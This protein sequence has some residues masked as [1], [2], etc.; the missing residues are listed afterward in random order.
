MSSLA[1]ARLG[2]LSRVASASGAANGSGVALS[3]NG[4]QASSQ[5]AGISGASYHSSS[6]RDAGAGHRWPT[7]RASGSTTEAATAS[8]VRR[9]IPW[10]VILTS[11][12]GL[13][14]IYHGACIFL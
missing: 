1:L 10:S 8:E 4:N 12:T 5:L 2:S 14:M 6:L 7:N 13:I 9:R 3:N 11:K